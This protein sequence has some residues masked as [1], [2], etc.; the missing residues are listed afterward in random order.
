LSEALGRLASEHSIT[1][2]K[3]RPLQSFKPCFPGIGFSTVQVPNPFVG[4]SR[5]HGLELSQALERRAAED[6]L[7][8][9]FMELGRVKAEIIL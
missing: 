1:D 3:W 8:A 5:S 9:I 7:G 6:I 2:S 4:I